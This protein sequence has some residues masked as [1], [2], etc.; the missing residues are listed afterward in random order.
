VPRPSSVPLSRSHPALALE[1]HPTKNGDWTTDNLVAGTNRKLWWICKAISDTPCGHEWQSIGAN[2]SR[3]GR[4]CPACSNHAVHID[5]RNSMRSTHPNLAEELHPTRN[6]DL[7][8]SD[9][10]A[11]THHEIWWRC[12]TISESPCGYEW[13][14]SGKNRNTGRGCT[15]CS[16]RMIHPD[17]SNSMANTHPELA[18]EWHPTKN[19]D[20]T[21][22]DVVAGSKKK[23]WWRC[24][25]LSES[26]CG[27]EWLT[28]LFHRKRG[29]GCSVCADH[30]FN[31]NKPAHLYCLKFQ[32]PLGDFWKVGI[33]NDIGIRRGH[34]QLAIS[35][36]QMYRDYSVHIFD[37]IRFVKGSDAREVEEKLLEMDDI[38]FE[39]AE[40]FD[41]STELFSQIPE[42]FL[43]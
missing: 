40:K 38:R 21:P 35:Q 11:G 31:P 41:G 33:T 27:H 3:H 18:A 6:G 22:N 32:G 36:T 2:R 5:G 12:T 28:T 24:S 13:V 9:V 29:S 26:P 25:T 19:G 7:T 30:G 23:V 14:A 34:L 17:H 37:S 42:Y 8:P 43:G 15:V 4:G 10:V 39:S 20:L 16:N 1:F